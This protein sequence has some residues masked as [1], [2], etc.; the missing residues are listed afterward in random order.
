[1]DYKGQVAVITGAA[2]GLGLGLARACAARGMKLALADINET[3]LTEV[4]EEM[5]K[6]G[7]ELLAEVI[8][9]SQA[10]DIERF[11]FHTFKRFGQVE[12]LFNNAGV[13]GNYSTFEATLKDWEWVIGVNMWGVVNSLR[14]FVPQML[15]SGKNGHIINIA[16]LA[17]FLSMPG[18]SIYRMTKSAV[19]SLSE[20]LYHEMALAKTAIK[21][22]VVSPAFI[23]TDIINAERNRP[24]DMQNIKSMPATNSMEEATFD[25]VKQQ[26]ESGPE[27]DFVAEAIFSGIDQGK[28]YI[29]VP[30]LS[31]A[32]E[33]RQ[34]VRHRMEALLSE[35]N[36]INP[37]YQNR[38]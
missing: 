23:K 24:V 21:V 33:L 5:T 13:F 37:L 29:F 28:L 35:K 16:G 1:M 26:V 30:S 22:S 19:V 15:T 18:S 36:Q 20:S 32:P 3:K 4:A 17:G 11:A 2:S 31:E 10:D 38:L 6:Q 34:A 8:D 25:W 14:A 7:L 9:V 27:P 12:L